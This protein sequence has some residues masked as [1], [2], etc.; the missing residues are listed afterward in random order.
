MANRNG[1]G[2][3][4]GGSKSFVG[5]ENPAILLDREDVHS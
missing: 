4:D 3:E 1:D 2:N 5:L